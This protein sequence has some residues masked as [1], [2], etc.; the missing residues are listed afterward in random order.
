[1]LNFVNTALGVT[2]K[3]KILPNL[4]ESRLIDI[5]NLSSDLKVNLRRKKRR[6]IT[7][8]PKQMTNVECYN[9]QRN[10][11]NTNKYKRRC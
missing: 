2:N 3:N 10:I 5:Y 1:M 11:G 9:V 8:K 4:V 6:R 7:A